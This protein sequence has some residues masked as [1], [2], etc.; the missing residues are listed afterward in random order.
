MEI[1]E[2]DLAVLNFGSSGIAKNNISV[3]TDVVE[4]QLISNS[5]LDLT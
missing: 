4:T 1:M 3:M 2:R 5:L